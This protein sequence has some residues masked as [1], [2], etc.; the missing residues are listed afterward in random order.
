MLLNGQFIE[1]F[2]DDTILQYELNATLLDSQGRPEEGTGVR[3]AKEI[4]SLFFTEFLS[5]C[6]VGRSDKVPCVRH[7][8]PRS[9]WCSVAS[10]LIAGVKVGYYPLFTCIYGISIFRGEQITG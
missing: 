6:A 4:I 1:L 10:I 2:K 3:V 9:E 8:M 7:D 5:S